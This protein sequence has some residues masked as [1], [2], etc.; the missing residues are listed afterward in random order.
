MVEEIHTLETKAIKNPDTSHNMEPSNRPNTVSSTPSH[1][2]TLTDLSGTKRSRLE[3]MDMMGFNRGNV[4]LTLEL[5]R[6]VDN[7]IQTQTQTQDHQFG[8]GD[9]MFHDFVG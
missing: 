9:H 8:T 3:Y 5:R 6:G 1:E 7:V 2:Q 4:S